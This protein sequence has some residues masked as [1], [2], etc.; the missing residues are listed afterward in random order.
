LMNCEELLLRRRQNFRA[1]LLHFI[2]ALARL[3]E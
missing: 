2:Y 3:K 1:Q